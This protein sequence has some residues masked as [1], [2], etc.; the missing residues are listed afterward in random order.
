MGVQRGKSFVA[1]RHGRVRAVN[2]L[3]YPAWEKTAH[4]RWAQCQ[5]VVCVVVQAPFR[6]RLD[7]QLETVFEPP[8]RVR[9]QERKV[10][11]HTRVGSSDAVVCLG[12]WNARATASAVVRTTGINPLG[13]DP[14]GRS[15]STL[16]ADDDDDQRSGPCLK[17]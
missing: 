5:L 9:Q 12:S 8:M 15:L 2:G 17:T 10:L 6:L 14:L 4:C 16:G 1:H 7:F 11:S 13:Q 3:L